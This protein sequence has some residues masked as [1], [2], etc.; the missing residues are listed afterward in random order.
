[1]SLPPTNCPN[2]NSEQRFSTRT[3][4]LDQSVEVYTICKMCKTRLVI[5]TYDLDEYREQRRA[6]LKR[7]RAVRRQLRSS[8]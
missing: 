2:C 6:A 7:N 5:A 1:M 8:R 3:L 4:V